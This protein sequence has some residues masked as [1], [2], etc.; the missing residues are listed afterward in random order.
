MAENKTVLGKHK[1]GKGCLY[2]RRLEDVDTKVLEKLVT[3]SVAD[4]KQR[5]K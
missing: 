1:G 5:Y 3:K 4:V 2:I